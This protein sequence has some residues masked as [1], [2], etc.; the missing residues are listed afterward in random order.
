MLF[1]HNCLSLDFSKSFICIHFHRVCYINDSQIS[2]ASSDTLT[3]FQIYISNYFLGTST[4]VFWRQFKLNVLRTSIFSYSTSSSLYFPL[5]SINTNITH[6]ITPIITTHNRSDSSPF[7]LLSP[8][9]SSLFPASMNFFFISS[10]S[11]SWFWLFNL[12]T[13]L[14]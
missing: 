13:K 3:K 1:F 10:V 5:I 8:S 9:I 6:Q 11:L 12:F 7:Y 4:Y 2:I 14:F